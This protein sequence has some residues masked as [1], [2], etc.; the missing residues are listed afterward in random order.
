MESKSTT[1]EVHMSSILHTHRDEVLEIE[2]SRY[3]L[4]LIYIYESDLSVVGLDTDIEYIL[5][6]KI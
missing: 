3:A 2:I 4:T 1:S 6:E 5:I